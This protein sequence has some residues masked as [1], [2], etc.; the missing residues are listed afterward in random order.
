M[1]VFP[2]GTAPKSDN[3]ILAGGDFFDHVPGRNARVLRAFHELI[4]F[5][6]TGIAIENRPNAAWD[7]RF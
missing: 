7:S 6:V 1:A 4:S 5:A 2:V 3:A